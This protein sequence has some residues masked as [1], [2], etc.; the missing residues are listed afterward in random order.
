MNEKIQGNPENPDKKG[1]LPNS[2]MFKFLVVNQALSVTVAFAG[3]MSVTG[4][5]FKLLEMQGIIVPATAHLKDNYGSY[6][7]GTAVLLALLGLHRLVF[8]RMVS[9]RRFRAN[10]AS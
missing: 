4:F 3:C 2:A 7:F 9:N 6:L 1:E 10:P 8:R 5:F